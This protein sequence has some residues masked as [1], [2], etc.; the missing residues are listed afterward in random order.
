MVAR[1]GKGITG[2]ILTGGMVVNS[3]IVFSPMQSASPQCYKEKYE[4]IYVHNNFI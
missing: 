3:Q 1:R 2:E 4:A